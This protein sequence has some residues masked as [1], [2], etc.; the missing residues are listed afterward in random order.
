MA[1]IASFEESTAYVAYAGSTAWNYFSSWEEGRRSWTSK[2]L[3]IFNDICTAGT[4]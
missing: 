3:I 2:C 4:T 1:R